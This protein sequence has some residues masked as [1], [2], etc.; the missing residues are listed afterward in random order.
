[1]RLPECHKTPSRTGTEKICLIVSDMARALEFYRTLGLPIP[2][3][4]AAEDHVEIEVDGLRIARETEGLMRQ[5]DAN[6]TPPARA[7]RLGF[8]LQAPSP[9]GVD[10]AVERVRLAGHRVKT[11]PWDAPWGQRYATVLDPDGTPVVLFAWRP[12]KT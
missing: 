6:W 3:D 2:V 10:E 11:E 5:L 9:A 12:E 4:T 1:M 7:G 8:A